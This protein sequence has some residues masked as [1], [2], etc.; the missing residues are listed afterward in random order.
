LEASDT[1]TTAIA[2]I[3]ERVDTRVRADAL[4]RQAVLG[5]VT[6]CAELAGRTDVAARAAVERIRLD[7]DALTGTQELIAGA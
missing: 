3:G 2:V 1:T 5:T 7:I 6:A 4:A